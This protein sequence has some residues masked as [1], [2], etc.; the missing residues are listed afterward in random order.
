MAIYY[1]QRLINIFIFVRVIFS[2]VNPNPHSGLV[3]FIYGV[4]EPILAPVRNLI[5][6]L[7]YNG[8]IDFSPIAAILLVNMI[9][10]VIIRLVTGL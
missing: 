4:T 7:G 3:Q 8:M 6:R 10:S 5:H 1:L 9:T 2:W